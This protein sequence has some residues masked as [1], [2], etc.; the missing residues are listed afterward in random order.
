[1]SEII[2]IELIIWGQFIQPMCFNLYKKHVYVC[3]TCMSSIQNKYKQLFYMHMQVIVINEPNINLNYLNAKKAIVIKSFQ[4]YCEDSMVICIPNDFINML[5]NVNTF[6]TVA[7]HSRNIYLDD[8][9][10]VNPKNA[11]LMS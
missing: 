8:T 11:G 2:Y 9:I 6:L 4:V 1:M 3:A 7:L 10:G 5:F